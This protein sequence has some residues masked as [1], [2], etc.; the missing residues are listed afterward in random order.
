M[1]KHW[2]LKESW[3]CETVCC[4]IL[5]LVMTSHNVFSILSVF[6]S[7]VKSSLLMRERKR[8]RERERVC[9]CVSLCYYIQWTACVCPYANISNGLRV[10]VCVCVCGPMLI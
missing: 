7:I 4:E 9:V 3:Y 8:E 10:F 5:A 6:A 2:A 1:L